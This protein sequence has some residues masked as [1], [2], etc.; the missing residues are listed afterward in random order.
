LAGL[1]APE[2]RR[3]LAVALPAPERSV[4][5]RLAWSRWRR[6]RRLQARRSHYRRRATRRPTEQLV[7][8]Q[9]P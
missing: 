5:A 9:S 2:V 7:L 3:R 8:A 1:T 4:A 6:K